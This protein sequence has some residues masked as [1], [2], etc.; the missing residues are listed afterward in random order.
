MP[1]EKEGSRP[2]LALSGVRVGFADQPLRVDSEGVG[3]ANF[4][5]SNI[6]D[7]VYSW[8]EKVSLELY[9]RKEAAGYV[10]ERAHI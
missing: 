6:L 9:S 7:R 3:E 8:E 10:T 5:P 2:F 4:F 1:K